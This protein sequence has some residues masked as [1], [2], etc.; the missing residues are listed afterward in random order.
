MRGVFVTATGTEVGKTWIACGLARAL[1]SR[2]HRVAAI[3]PVE[4][5]CDPDPADALALGE[6]CGNLSL[7]R[8]DGLYRAREPLGPYAIVRRG[9]PEVPPLSSLAARV[10]ELGSGADV[11]IAEGAGGVLVP[12]DRERTFADFAIALGL[13]AIVVAE[14]ALG[15]QSFTLTAVEALERRGIEVIAVVLN[16]R[17]DDGSDLSQ[18]SNQEV[19]AALLPQLSVIAAPVN[20]Y[21]DELTDLVAPT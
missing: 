21:A 9:G 11:V 3:K 15:V 13:P 6:A 8:A 7:A 18:T 12:I 2:G 5:G 10:R 4:T 16:Q 19:L 1:V 17:T 14:N 20:G